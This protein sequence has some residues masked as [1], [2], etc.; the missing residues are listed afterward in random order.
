M[1][2]NDGHY[3]NKGQEDASDG[4]YE[5]PHGVLDSLFTWRSDEMQRHIE[6]NVAYRAGHAQTEG[7]TDG[8]ANEYD[9]PSDPDDRK[10]YDE[11]WETSHGET[12]DSGGCF[13]TTACVSYAGLPDDCVELETLRAFRDG[14]VRQR[15]DGTTV[16][17]EYYR[18]A[19]QIV[20]QIL[21]N[22][23]REACLRDILHAVRQ[24]VALIAR[25]EMQQAFDVYV[26]M[27][28]SLRW[29]VSL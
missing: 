20:Q 9:P 16:I 3:H 13:L 12:H 28:Q 24:A 8:A 23:D 10:V 14:Y 29:R 11:A 21:E 7:Q 6:E 27:V 22:A 1:S 5:P 18:I 2:S 26:S 25:G 17:A 4:K 19:P 15:P